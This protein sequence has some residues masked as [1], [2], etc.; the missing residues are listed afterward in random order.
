MFIKISWKN[1]KGETLNAYVES[2]KV[3]GFINTFVERDLEPSLT[4]PESVVK[5]QL[6][7]THS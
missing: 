5:N 2:T 7:L 3:Q 4:M 1:S 6:I